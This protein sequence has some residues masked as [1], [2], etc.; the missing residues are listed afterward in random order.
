[1]MSQ[2]TWYSSPLVFAFICLS[3]VLFYFLGVRSL[4]KIQTYTK[5]NTLS[6][7]SAK[8]KNYDEKDPYLDIESENNIELQHEE[9]LQLRPFRPKFHLTMALENTTFSEF[10]LMDKTYQSRIRLRRHLVETREHDTIACNPKAN[11]AVLELYSWL[12]TTYLPLRFPTAFTL[13]THPSNA[14]TQPHLH[15]TLTSD[16][17]PLH[18]AS[19]LHAL[20][21]LGSH[22][23][24][25]ILLL[26]PSS[27]TTK[28]HLEAFATCF[29][30]GFNTRAKLGLGLADIHTPVPGYAQKLERS[31]DRF[32]AGLPRGK[33]VKRANWSVTTN[34]ELFCLEGNHGKVEGVGGAGGVGGEGLPGG[35]EGEREGE[36]KGEEG[37][38]E[39]QFEIEDCV[40]RCERQTLHRLPETGALVFAF[41]TY[42]YELGDVKREGNGEALAQAIE[43]LRAGSVPS[44]NVYKRGA[45]WGKKVKE[46][47]RT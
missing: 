29:P 36:G 44:I 46:Y 7:P 32:F 34:R 27:T 31:M 45:V 5:S 3:I 25:D 43:G 9:P 11:S 22:I 15:N 23:D 40:L 35:R 26:L 38:E 18:P 12:T 10:L 17:L 2:Q 28:Y 20:R 33:M 21:L 37:G 16:S 4:P 13:S 8:G 1:M 30:S 24:T 42:Q 14:S 41:K 39:E 19:P 47:L 6:Q